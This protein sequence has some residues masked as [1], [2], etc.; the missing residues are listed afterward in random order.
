VGGYRILR[1]FR[2]HPTR[3]GRLELAGGQI[4]EGAEAADEVVGAQTALA[5]EPAHKFFSRTF[6]LF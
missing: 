5:E 2:G 6:G 3:K 1:A 4:V